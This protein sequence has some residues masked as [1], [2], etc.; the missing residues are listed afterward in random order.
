M[1]ATIAIVIVAIVVLY[2]CLEVALR[3]LMSVYLI[4]TWLISYITPV[5]LF[6]ELA[7]N[8]SERAELR[9]ATWQS[10]WWMWKPI[11]ILGFVGSVY[12]LAFFGS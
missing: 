2:F 10:L 8:A 7:D 6:R 5:G 12:Y 11:W 3:V 4:G 9:V 1:I